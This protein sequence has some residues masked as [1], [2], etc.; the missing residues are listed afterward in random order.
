MRYV[1]LDFETANHQ[2]GSACA[3]AI[4][5]IEDGEIIGRW[6]TLINPEAEFAPMNMHIHGIKPK[7]VGDAPT[8]ADLAGPLEEL[9]NGVEA[10][11]AHSAAFDIQVMRASAARYQVEIPAFRFACTRVFSRQWFPGWP[12]YA[13]TYCTGQLGIEETLGSDHH[14][15]VWDAEAAALIAMEGL[16]RNGHHSWQEAADAHRIHLGAFDPATYMGCTSIQGTS[17]SIAPAVPDGVNFDEDHPLYGRTVCFTGALAHYVRREAAQLVA[18]VGGNFS[19]GVTRNTDLL[20]VGEQDL[21]RLSGHE[22]S[23]K[24]RKAMDMAASGHGIEIIDELDFYQ[25]LSG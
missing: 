20:V 11:V 12:S 3:I 19:N 1:A 14:N 7:D 2:R 5:S 21:A 15:P 9:I 16:R 6:S 10:V 17:S 18:N 4:V 23:S 25:M 22:V 24:M 8:F 13:L